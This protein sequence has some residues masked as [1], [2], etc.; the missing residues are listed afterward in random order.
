MKI[1]LGY[2][3]SRT[4]K[5]ALAHARQAAV[6]YGAQVSIVTSFEPGS[7]NK[8]KQVKEIQAAEQ[9]LDYAKIALEKAQIACDTHLLV[10]GVSPGEDLVD[11]ANRHQIDQ[12]II[13][14]KKRSKVGKL[15][16]GSTAQ[17]VILKAPCPVLT[18]R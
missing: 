7:D 18:V 16:F 6:A 12:I 10:H 3:G 2:D 9:A 5:D 15:L 17:Y 11:F 14:V 13:G 8:E 4:S 1:L